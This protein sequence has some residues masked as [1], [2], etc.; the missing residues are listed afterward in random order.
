MPFVLSVIVPSLSCGKADFAF[1]ADMYGEVFLNTR[2]FVHSLPTLFASVQ[3]FDSFESTDFT[4]PDSLRD[5]FNLDTQDPIIL[6]GS[7]DSH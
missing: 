4:I 6:K 2:R 7:E 3:C 1:T 5:T